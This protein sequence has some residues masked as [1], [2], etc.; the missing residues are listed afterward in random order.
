M[1]RHLAL[2]L[3]SRLAFIRYQMNPTCIFCKIIAEEAP[4]AIVY[5]DEQVTAFRDK[6]P[7]AQTHVLIVPNKHIASVNQAE[8]E[9]EAMLGHLFIVARKIAAMDG[10]AENGYRLIVN[11]GVHGGQTVF[12]LHVHLIGG[13]RL[14][15]S[16]G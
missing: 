3:Y 10:I 2:Q 9:D 13:Q 6:H 1:L 16:L 5:K 15:A 12:H 8:P 7:V 4:A 11:T 14:R